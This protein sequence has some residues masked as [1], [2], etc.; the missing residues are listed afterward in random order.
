MPLTCP[1]RPYWPCAN[2][3]NTT[4]QSASPATMEAAALATAAQ[5][6]PPPPPHC[7]VVGTKPVRAERRGQP[8]GFVSIVAVGR[9]SVDVARIKSC[10][11]ARGENG[12]QRELELRIRRRA[13]AIIIGLAD[14]DHGNAAP[15]RPLVARL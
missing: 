2:A 4:T 7:I 12:F 14:A 1:K 13:V 8:R 5:Q 6:P 15:E 11:L 10:V 3:R 9:E